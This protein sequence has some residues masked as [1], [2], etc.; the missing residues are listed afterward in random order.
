[1]SER[2]FS[3]IKVGVFVFFAA[4]IVLATL[5]WAKGFMVS[6]DQNDLKAYFKNVSGLNIGDPVTVNGVRKGKV[7][8]FDLEGDSV[9]V[10]L[11]LEKTVKIKKDY[12]IEIAMLELMAGKQV[13]ISPGVDKDEIDYTK[14]LI[15]ETG[16]DITVMMKNLNEITQDVKGLMKKFDK[17]VEDL[18]ITINNV[19]EVVGDKDVHNNLKNTLA[20]LN[21]ASKNLNTLLVENRY[22]FKDITGKVGKTVDNVNSMLDENSPQVKSTFKDIQTLTSRID[23]L[24][25]SINVVVGDIQNQKGSVGKFMYDDKLYENLN[26]SLL[27][28]EKLSKKIRKDGIKINL[29]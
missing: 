10:E 21:S 8:K 3:E 6:K 25:S 17:T 13:L 20:N 19:N 15:G 23:T 22:T 16:S 14:P 4:F 2:K 12:K 24:I 18:D 11:T 5:F 28:I 1:M 27:E 9:L 29:F 7:K 26:K